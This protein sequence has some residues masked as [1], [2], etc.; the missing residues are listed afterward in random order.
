[1]KRKAVIDM[2]IF[3]AIDAIILLFALGLVLSFVA[4]KPYD[5]IAVAGF[6]S[7]ASAIQKTCLEGKA[8]TVDFEMAQSKP[9]T[10]GGTLNVLRKVMLDISGD[11]DYL[12]YY[13]AY[14]PGDA[15]AWE[16][17]MGLPKRNVVYYK[18]DLCEM[19]SDEKCIVRDF[20]KIKF[21]EFVKQLSDP[22][23]TETVPFVVANIIL[24]DEENNVQYKDR[25]LRG[26]VGK[27]D[28]TNPNTKASYNFMD[29]FSINTIEKTMVKY[30]ACGENS[31]CLKT[32][33]GVYK[34]PLTG[35][36]SI[37][38]N[39]KLV[40]VSKKAGT[41]PST[42]EILLR[43]AKNLVGINAGVS[44]EFIQ[45]RP[46]SLAS[47]CSRSTLSIVR[48]QCSCKEKRTYPI[49]EYSSK[50]DTLTQVGTHIDCLDFIIGGQAGTG[51][52]FDCISIGIENLNLND[53]YC[54]TLP[55]TS[56]SAKQGDGPVSAVYKYD[57]IERGVTLMESGGDVSLLSKAVELVTPG[58]LPMWPRAR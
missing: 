20:A 51:E 41:Y 40:V 54:I 21:P 16:E 9:I 14:P 25:L 37:N 35:C 23:S 7:L 1:M 28:T 48:T 15:W 39:D 4:F 10:V 56:K 49:F 27:W 2:P 26:T 42:I 29:Y 8:V 47:P 52:T 43:M 22:Q 6:E 55:G 13:E 19:T 17:L 53:N 12:I 18:P 50:D 33:K 45:R 5:Q 36:E 38:E 3:L 24:D 46:L 11:P 32:K 57:N 34:I 58:F 30:R 44:A 31:L